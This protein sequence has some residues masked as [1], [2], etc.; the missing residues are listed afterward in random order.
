[1]I[2]TDS[3]IRASDQDREN[4]VEVLRDAYTAGRLTLEEFHERIT[5]A[6]SGRTWGALRELTRDLPPDARLGPG[7]LPGQPAR[8][9]AAVSADRV[10]GRARPVAPPAVVKSRVP[11]ILPIALFWLA[12]SIAAR[13]PDALIPAV[14]V[15]LLLL[16]S[17]ES[18]RARQ[19]YSARRETG[20]PLPPGE[21]SGRR[22]TR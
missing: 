22:H 8:P 15:M 16:S 18:C 5:A 21:R 14:L 1:M 3:T 20:R 9:R 19:S 11:A 6:F 2:T 4:V 10:P 13:T 7:L 17:R 12:L